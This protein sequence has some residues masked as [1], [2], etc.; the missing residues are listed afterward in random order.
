MRVSSAWGKVAFVSNWLKV[1][2]VLRAL[3]KLNVTVLPDTAW[4]K[5]ESR[6]R[7]CDV[8]R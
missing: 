6:A 3:A 1:A 2:V 7:R 5:F 8:G 4:P